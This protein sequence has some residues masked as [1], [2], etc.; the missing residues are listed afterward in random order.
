MTLSLPALGVAFMLGVGVGWLQAATQLAE[1][2][3][4]AITRL[5]GVGLV[6]AASA[7]WMGHELVQFTEQLW[8]DLPGM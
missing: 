2:A 8:R 3:V 6:L 5:V 7:R 1:P 4:N